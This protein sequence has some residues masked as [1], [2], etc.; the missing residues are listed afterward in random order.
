MDSR[1]TRSGNALNQRVL[2][3]EDCERSR[4]FHAHRSCS[5]CQRQVHERV[6]E[7]D[8]TSGA[9]CVDAVA[10]IGDRLCGFSA[11]TSCQYAKSEQS[12][13]NGCIQNNSKN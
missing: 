4:Q 2:R 1:D 10:L 8:R 13:F 3:Q 5:V 9:T 11:G 6:S 12:I 7:I